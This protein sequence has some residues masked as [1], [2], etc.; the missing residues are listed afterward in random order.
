[1]IIDRIRNLAVWPIKISFVSLLPT[2][3]NIEKRINMLIG[4]F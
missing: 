1:M 3:E 2:K 4:I